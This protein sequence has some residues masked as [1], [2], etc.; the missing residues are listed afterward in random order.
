MERKVI[1]RTAITII[2]EVIEVK[3]NVYAIKFPIK[4][5]KNLANIGVS[6]TKYWDGKHILFVSSNYNDIIHLAKKYGIPEL[7][8]FK[9][10]SKEVNYIEK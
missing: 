1:S 5:V 3:N 7:M 10:T 4:E 8:V 9:T 2:K 6:I